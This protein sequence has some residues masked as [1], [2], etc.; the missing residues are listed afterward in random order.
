MGER[1]REVLRK[2][3]EKALSWKLLTFSRI[4]D[5]LVLGLN[6]RHDLY[7]NKV[8]GVGERDEDGKEEKCYGIGKKIKES[9]K[10][11]VVFLM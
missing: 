6:G 3:R 9:T 5:V 8:E 11:Q 2:K 4:V 1:R 10:V 7:R